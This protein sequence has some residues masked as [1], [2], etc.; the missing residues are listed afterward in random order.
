MA[1]GTLQRGEVW[2]VD[3]DPVRGH[4]QGRRRPAVLVSADIFNQG[5]AQL[6]VICPMTTRDRGI[7]SR[8]SIAPP[9]GGV[10]TQS[11]V[12]CEQVRTISIHRLGPYTGVV[13]AAT[14][15]AIDERLRILLD[16]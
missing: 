2:E 11:Y 4:E 14:M 1:D 13:S 6:V 7:P 5:K 12:I 8:V 9:E 15:S 3:L 10:R 16:L